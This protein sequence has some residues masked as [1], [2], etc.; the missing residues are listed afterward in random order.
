MRWMVGRGA[1]G[2]G[3]T[4]C[5]ISRSIW[6]LALVGARWREGRWSFNVAVETP[7]R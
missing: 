2:W 3:E 4:I 5:T 6:S 7:A 1:A